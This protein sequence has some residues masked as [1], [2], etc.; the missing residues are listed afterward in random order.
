VMIME[1]FLNR[2]P[3]KWL[4]LYDEGVERLDLVKLQSVFKAK[5]A[6][7]MTKWPLIH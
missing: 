1:N 7:I 4:M 2:T 5:N 6:V 3:N